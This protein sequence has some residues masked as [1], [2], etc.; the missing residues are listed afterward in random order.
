MAQ[1]RKKSEIARDRR[2]IS[3]LYLQGI[4]QMAIA[5][6]LGLSQS[7]ISRD[8]FYI[9]KEWQQARINDIDENKKKE[10]ARID[11]LER[12][13]WD[14]WRRSQEKSKVEVTRMQG[15][16]SRPDQT[17]TPAPDKLEKMSRTED[18][19]GDPR[20]LQGVAWCINKRAELLGLNSYKSVTFMGKAGKDGNELIVRVEYNETPTPE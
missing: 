17:T 16:A 14:A 15:K 9:E 1:S 3:R 5:E 4:T 20:F 11:N 7:T 18:N 12:E 6:Q 19:V 10:L 2:N 8:L 13:Y